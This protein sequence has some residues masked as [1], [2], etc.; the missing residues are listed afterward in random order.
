MSRSA[1]RPLGPACILLLAVLALPAPARAAPPER[2]LRILFIGNS[3]T[4]FNDLPGIVAA[5][6]VES[7]REKPGCQSEVQGGYSLEDHWIRGDALKA[8]E[9]GPWDYV[10]LQQGP[11]ATEDGR[12]V[13]R[14]YARRFDP[15]IRKTGGKPALYMVWPAASDPRSFGAIADTYRLA[16]RDV[17][18]ILLPAGEAWRL[19]QKQ[20][21]EIALYGPDGF[22]PSPVGSYLAALVVVAELYGISPIGL[23]PP[24]PTGSAVAL[25]LPPGQARILQEA[26]A[27]AIAAA[28]STH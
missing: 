10:V 27:S 6:V 1:L 14:Q 12:D 9:A 4:Y 20:A 5:L 28:H 8:I 3:L 23:D 25:R 16:A 19:V 2:A 7:G 17:G 15:A 24:V 11:S 26:A 22:H 21:P 13:L 18:G